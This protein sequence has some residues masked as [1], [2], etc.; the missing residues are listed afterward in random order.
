MLQWCSICVLVSVI[1]F[2]SCTPSLSLHDQTWEV[3]SCQTCSFGFQNSEC[4]FQEQDL[5][6]PGHLKHLL[7]AWD[8]ATFFFF[9]LMGEYEIIL[10][11]F[12]LNWSH[13]LGVSFQ[14][15]IEIRQATLY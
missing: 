11:E 4:D 13:M 14:R 2:P 6:C 8:S 9:F 7:G 15:R 1:T 12:A 5:Q 10:T 3:A